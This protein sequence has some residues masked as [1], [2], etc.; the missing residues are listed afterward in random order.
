MTSINGQT[1]VYGVIGDPIAHSFSPHLHN[2]VF[3]ARGINAVY[4]PFH[5][6]ADDLPGAIEGFKSL[7]IK[8]LNITLPHKEQS[9]HYLDNIP[10]SMDKVTGAVNTIV[11]SE[12]RSMG[13]NTDGSAFVEDLK[14]QF[15]LNPRDK[16]A[17]LIGA[18]GAARAIAFALLGAGLDELFIFNRTPERA[19]GLA[20]YL[21][22][23]FD[24]RRIQSILSIEDKGVEE[25]DLLV[26]ATSCGMGANDP[27]PINPDILTS[28]EA[29]Y[30]VIY[31]PL[32]TKMVLK[33]REHKI[34]ACGGIGM[35]IG[36]AVNAHVLWFPEVDKLEVRRIMQEAFDTWK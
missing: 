36:Q 22:Q 17:I 1:Q 2:A 12:G 6:K 31:S 19:D 21:A 7:G 35:L 10:S 4:V 16:K 24:D 27:L 33:A 11:V 9:V 18:G 3:K 23:Y 20:K 15:N 32:E 30:D 26:N 25:I 5:V 14:A 8:G 28:I 13:F 29:Y 34:K